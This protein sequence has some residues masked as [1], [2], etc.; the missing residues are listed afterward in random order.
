MK[1]YRVALSVLA[2]CSGRSLARNTPTTMVPPVRGMHEMVGAANNFE[3]E[4]GLPHPHRKAATPWMRA[5]P[6]CWPPASPN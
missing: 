4:A 6:A 3:V 5:W 2:V 1:T